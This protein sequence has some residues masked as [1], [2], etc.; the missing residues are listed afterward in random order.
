VLA[1]DIG[2]DILPALALGAEPPGRHLLDRPPVRRH[3]LDRPLF[4][5]AFGVLGPVEAVVALTAFLAVFVAGGWRPGDS[6]PEG[7]PLLT[8]SGAAFTAVVLGQLANAF[9]CRST[10]RPA[11]QVGWTSNRILLGAIAA[12]L[13]MLAGFLYIP[14]VA[15]L[16]DHAPPPWAGFAV[17]LIAIPAVLAADAAQKA[18]AR[19]RR[20]MT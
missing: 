3:L 9:A 15:D 19:R 4:L 6:F 12:E 1:L 10:T 5:R 16:L 11:W 14:P 2:T 17:G 8:A 13:A 18:V 20:A 7:Q